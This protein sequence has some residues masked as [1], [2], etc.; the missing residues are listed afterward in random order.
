MP[1]HILKT[2]I[3]NTHYFLASPQSKF[4]VTYFHL[5]YCWHG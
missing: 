2:N 4:N 1:D 3:L 5:L